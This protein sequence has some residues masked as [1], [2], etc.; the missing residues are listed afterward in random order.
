MDNL[1]GSDLHHQIKNE[2]NLI[3]KDWNI[4]SEFPDLTGHK[5][6]AVDLE[7]K[8]PNIKTLGPGWARNDGHI[9][10]VAVAAG[11]DKWYFPMRHQN[12]HNLD[13][14]MV[15]KWI[16]RQLS[17][18]DM[19]IIMHNA[20]YDAGWLRAE[21]V[22]IKGNIIDTENRWSFGLDAMARDYAGIRKDEKLLKA[23]AEAWG[24]DPKAEMW[25][26]PPMYVGAYAEQD[27]LATLKLWQ[28]LRIELEKQDLWSI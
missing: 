19:N 9:I 20:T 3:D 2:L 28:S 7:T 13:A 14:K 1:F 23:A 10:G 5:E 26:L 11:E 12:G 18:P 24:I 15:L 22:E 25:Q 6:I 16:N 27:A 4:P 17:I 21:G 8:D